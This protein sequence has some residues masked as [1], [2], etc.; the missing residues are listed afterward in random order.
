[1][2]DVLVYRCNPVEPYDRFAIEAW[3]AAKR[4]GGAVPASGPVDVRVEHP[5]R[6]ADGKCRWCGEGSNETLTLGA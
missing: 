5:D 2:R 6:E 4:A 1:M 3:L